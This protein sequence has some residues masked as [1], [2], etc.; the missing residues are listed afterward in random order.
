MSELLNSFFAPS[1]ST[2]LPS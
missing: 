1:H 2:Q